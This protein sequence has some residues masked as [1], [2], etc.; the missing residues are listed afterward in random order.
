VAVVVTTAAGTELRAERTLGRCPK[1]KHSHR[2]SR[3]HR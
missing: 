2:K 1:K 3:S